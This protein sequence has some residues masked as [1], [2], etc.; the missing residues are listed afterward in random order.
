MATT[1]FPAPVTSSINSD[2]LTAVSANVVYE[3]RKTFDPAIYTI[4]CAAATIT[5]FEFMSNTSTVI[6][7]GVT[8]SG[9]VSINL[10]S[11][12]DR[13][14]L[15]TNTG[16]NVVVTITKTASAL[17]N[18]FSGTLDT[19]T[20][21]TTY[22]QTS[23]SG[24]A[25]FIMAGGGGGGGNSNQQYGGGSGGG[26]GGFRS[27]IVALTGSMP[28]TVGTG[29]GIKA[30]GTSTTFAGFTCT[31]GGGGADGGSATGGTAG[32]PNGSAG[33]N[34]SASGSPYGS[35]GAGGSITSPYSFIT[36]GT[37]FGVG[38]RGGSEGGNRFDGGLG[39]GGG[40]GHSAGINTGGS[41]GNGV[42]YILRF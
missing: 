16:S 11:T 41:G 15:W 13:I 20:A 42:V 37:T 21:N 19:I 29:G 2:A 12:A 6:T 30:A 38:G 39:A 8:A 18:Q 32:T 9:T 23:P 5:N 33:G 4:T 25:Y 40:G 36:S 35:G 34:T 31:G 1:V 27:G 14:R 22:T 26:S 24:F 7:S 3:G 17:T 28:I 10:A